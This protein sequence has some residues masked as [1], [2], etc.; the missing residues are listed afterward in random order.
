MGTGIGL[1]TGAG[2][3]YRYRFRFRP[4]TVPE[5]AP[6]RFRSVTVPFLPSC[7]YGF[8][9]PDGPYTPGTLPPIGR[10]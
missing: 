10:M 9:S 8:S 3:V 2:I 7:S 1:G 6:S 5:P 4:G